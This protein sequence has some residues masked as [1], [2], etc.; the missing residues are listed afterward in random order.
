MPSTSTDIKSQLDTQL[1]PVIQGLVSVSVP[2]LLL[3]VLAQKG[4]GRW[5]ED[6]GQLSESLFQGR[7][8]P[9]LPFPKADSPE[10]SEMA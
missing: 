2:P 6:L 10:A 1:E 4:C 5:F 9:S 3:G 7:R 8:L